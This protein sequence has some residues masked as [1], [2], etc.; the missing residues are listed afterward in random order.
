MILRLNYFS[1]Y[2]WFSVSM[3]TLLISMKS[4]FCESEYLW[5]L[6]SF[7][8]ENPS[9]GM[10]GIDLSSSQLLSELFKIIQKKSWKTMQQKP[11]D[12]Y[13]R[14][15]Y[16]CLSFV[17]VPWPSTCVVTKQGGSVIVTAFTCKA[18][19]EGANILLFCSLWSP[20]LV[21]FVRYRSV[22]M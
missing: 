15:W 8:S 20:S 13:I 2:H 6:F 10:M 21:N 5:I 18:A 12:L 3:H 1:V 19:A 14:T 16:I 7:I 17:R 4:E 11:R 22:Q 9:R